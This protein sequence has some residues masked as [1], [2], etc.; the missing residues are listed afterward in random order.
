MRIAEGGV[1]LMERH[2]DRLRNSA[3]YFSFKCDLAKL[4]DAV[5]KV[6]PA[7]RNPARLRLTLSRDGGVAV[8]SGPLPTQTT[9]RL[10][11]SGCR[12][13]SKDQFLYH[14]TT[15]RKVY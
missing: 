10:K 15:N 2:L 4:R 1:F 13:N 14:K 12:V 11:L 5:F 8:E 9:R 7:D 3:R 6:I